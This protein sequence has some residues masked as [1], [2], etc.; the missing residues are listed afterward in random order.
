MEGSNSPEK[1]GQQQPQQ[2]G[3]GPV[4]ILVR[5]DAKTPRDVHYQ[6]TY[7]AKV[8]LSLS[9]CQIGLAGLLIIC[10]VSMI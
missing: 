2:G 7:P 5:P 9:L 6:K 3:P 1:Q 4:V 10:Q 8:T